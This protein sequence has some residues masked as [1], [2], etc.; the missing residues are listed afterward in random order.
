MTHDILQS[1]IDLARR[2]VERGRPD[3]EVV[4]AL[5]YR[6]IDSSRAAGL[7]AA[8]QDGKAV[9]ADKPIAINLPRKTT[10]EAIA[11]K[12]QHQ[13]LPVYSRAE[14][15]P[16]SKAKR[17]KTNAFPWF[18]TIVLASVAVCGGVFILLSR[19][20]HTADSVDKPVAQATVNKRPDSGGRLE[21]KD[22]LL[23]I[24]QSGLR[25]CGNPVSREDFL[26]A[27]FKILG[28]P[29]R[30]NQVENLDHVIYAYDAY[31][32]LIYSPRNS[33]NYSVVL[34]F[35]A[36]DG[37]A[38]TKNAFIGVFKVNSHVLDATTDAASL[39]LIREL[40]LEPPKSGSGIFRAQ[41]GE[42]E[43]VFGYFKT[44]ERLSLAEIDFK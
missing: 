37:D 27:I 38:G 7:V 35:E 12:S 23:E 22:I 43:L 33:G 13:T 3:D 6:G 15:S 1:D 4:A 32:V 26:S 11:A 10:A 24:Q 44:P 9:E 29:S 39:A 21:A 25:L 34:D 40:E 14:G 42:L 36:T 20:S 16:R 30:T 28:T 18:T 19:K 2:L 31:G 5:A 41:F 17:Q 8:L